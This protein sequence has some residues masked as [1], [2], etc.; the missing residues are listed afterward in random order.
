MALTTLAA[1][2]FSFV[3]CSMMTSCALSL[4]ACGRHIS[5]SEILRPLVML[6]E[7]AR[8]LMVLTMLAEV[9]CFYCCC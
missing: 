5:E 8:I 1:V 4:C 3:F 7:K 2:E 6:S 9:E